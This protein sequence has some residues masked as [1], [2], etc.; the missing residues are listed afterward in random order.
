MF[1]RNGKAQL[2]G[3]R[4][5]L[6]MPMLLLI[7]FRRLSRFACAWNDAM[8]CGVLR[9]GVLPTVSAFWRYLTSLGI[10]Q[11]ASLLR[12]PRARATVRAL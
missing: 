1:T 3:Y 7:G 4:M 5:V 8:V 10:V 12:P 9:G 11:S 2:G 6:G